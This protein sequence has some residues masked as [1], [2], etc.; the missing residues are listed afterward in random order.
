M[1][2]M[3]KMVS[4]TKLPV[5]RKAIIGPAVVITGIMAFFNTCKRMM[6]PPEMPLARAITT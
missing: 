5:S 6:R 3:V 1:P 4:T 2:G